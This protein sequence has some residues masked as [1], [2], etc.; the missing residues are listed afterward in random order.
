MEIKI[1]EF[2]KSAAPMDFS[3]SIAEIGENAGEQ[4]WRAA[5]EEAEDTQLLTN[6]EQIEAF[7]EFAKSSGFSEPD[8]SDKELQALFIQWIAGDMREMGLKRSSDFDSI[9]W[10]EI[11]EAQKQ[12]QIPS[13]IFRGTD[14]EIYFY[15]GS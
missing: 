1:T 15:A 12:G 13:N 8:L 9:N 11:E 4:T 14:D 5:L 2:F 7:R 6:Q 3:A 10:E